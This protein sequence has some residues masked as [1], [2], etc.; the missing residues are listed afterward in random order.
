MDKGLCWLLRYTLTFNILYMFVL[1]KPS[2]SRGGKKSRKEESDE[3]SMSE[4]G[5][6]GLSMLWYFELV[7]R[8]K[9]YIKNLC[10][11]I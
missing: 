7:F 6:T 4:W 5:F 10:V 8:L 1:Q 11:Y 3:E 9:S 2:L